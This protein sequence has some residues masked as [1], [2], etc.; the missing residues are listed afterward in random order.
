MPEDALPTADGGSTL[1]LVDAPLHRPL[2]VVEIGGGP[3]RLAR[4]S[5]LGV[6]PG[7]R[8]FLRQ[9]R[10]AYVL[11]CDETLLALERGVAERVRVL[12]G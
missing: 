4:L 7:C 1:D 9:K 6:V 8:V 11:E 5:G 3:E 10:P 12:P 2:T